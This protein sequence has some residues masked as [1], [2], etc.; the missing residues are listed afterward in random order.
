MRLITSCG[1]AFCLLMKL[2]FLARRKIQIALWI[3]RIY[4][5]FFLE[6][7]RGVEKRGFFEGKYNLESCKITSHFQAC[8]TIHQITIENPLDTA[9]N[10]KTN[11]E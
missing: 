11:D 5:G 2:F 7:R 1:I 8:F 4:L 9:G 10:F 6:I 3:V